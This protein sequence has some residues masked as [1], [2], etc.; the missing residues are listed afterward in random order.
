MGTEPGETVS[1]TSPV[2]HCTADG[3]GAEPALQGH[4]PPRGGVRRT[5]GFVSRC[6]TA[7]FSL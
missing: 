6:W 5:G 7:S 4:S 3:E 1:T 2:S